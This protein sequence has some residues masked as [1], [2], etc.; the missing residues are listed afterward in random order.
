LRGEGWQALVDRV[1]PK[2]GLDLDRLALVLLMV[3]LAGCASCH[4]D[5]LKAMR[6]CTQC[7]LQTLRRFRGSDE[8]LL[9][10]FAAARH[11]VERYLSHVE[12]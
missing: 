11:E 9:H 1:K 2:E 10:S 3:K 5:S 7:S 12:K 8:D 6:G 4:S